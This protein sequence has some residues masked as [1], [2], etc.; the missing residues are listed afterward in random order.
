MRVCRYA[1]LRHIRGIRYNYNYLLLATTWIVVVVVVHHWYL[2]FCNIFQ[3]KLFPRCTYLF[4]SYCNNGNNKNIGA[5]ATTFAA[6]ATLLFPL[7]HLSAVAASLKRLIR[8]TNR[9]QPPNICALSC[10]HTDGQ[11]LYIFISTYSVAF[12]WLAP[13][14]A[15]GRW[16]RRFCSELALESW[17]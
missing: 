2:L 16:L 4:T 1:F 17:V 11:I 9:S 8:H 3:Y 15:V 6:V 5:C 10:W 7:L 14:A 12:M 13:T